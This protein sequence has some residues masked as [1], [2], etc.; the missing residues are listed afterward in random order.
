MSFAVDLDHQALFMTREVRK[1]GADRGLPTKMR[2]R[3]FD[4]P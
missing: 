4:A 1:V 2:V 3:K